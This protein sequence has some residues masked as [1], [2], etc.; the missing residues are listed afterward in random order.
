MVFTH[1]K[2]DV[3]FSLGGNRLYRFQVEDYNH[4]KLA[5]FNHKYK[6]KTKQKKTKQNKT[7]QNKTKKE[8]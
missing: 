5:A 2:E 7:K 4:S 6:N 1:I 8:K 3:L